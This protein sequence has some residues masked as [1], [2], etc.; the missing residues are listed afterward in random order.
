MS[1]EISPIHKQSCVTNI[2]GEPQNRGKG[3][4]YNNM[5]VNYMQLQHDTFQ[6]AAS[7]KCFTPVRGDGYGDISALGDI[8]VILIPSIHH[9]V[10]QRIGESV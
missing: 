8:S 1:L 6:K 3:G 4:I 5:L 7:C 10:G 9:N 2:L